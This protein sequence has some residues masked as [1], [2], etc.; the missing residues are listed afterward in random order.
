METTP[1]ITKTICGLTAI[2]GSPNPIHPSTHRKFPKVPLDTDIPN[3]RIRIHLSKASQSW[4]RPPTGFGDISI[5]REFEP[6]PKPRD[7]VRVILTI[8]AN[9]E[10][11]TCPPPECC[12]LFVSNVD[13]C[14]LKAIRPVLLVPLAFVQALSRSGSVRHLTL[15]VSEGR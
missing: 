10:A 12:S 14:R 15:R 13:S 11:V 7:G 1:Y 3:G 8:R 4:S 9:Q 2:H 5:L 6:S